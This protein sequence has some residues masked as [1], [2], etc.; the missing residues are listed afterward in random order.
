MSVQNNGWLAKLMHDSFS[1]EQQ[2][3]RI[4]KPRRERNSARKIQWHC[5]CP[6][7]CT[8]I[9]RMRRKRSK[10]SK[11]RVDKFD[12]FLPSV[13]AKEGVEEDVGAVREGVCGQERGLFGAA[14]SLDAR[15]SAL[16]MEA[17]E[18]HA[19]GSRG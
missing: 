2:L 3:S 19:V 11:R 16:A 14:Q 13:L 12:R 6:S 5:V 18:Q 8:G 7:W 9:Q 15:E 10:G 17:V 1:G 4:G